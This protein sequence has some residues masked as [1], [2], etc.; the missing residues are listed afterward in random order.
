MGSSL[1]GKID[2]LFEGKNFSYL[3]PRAVYNRLIAIITASREQ[4]ADKPILHEILLHRLLEYSPHE[5]ATILR[6]TG[7]HT[8]LNEATLA[9]EQTFRPASF[10][11]TLNYVPSDSLNRTR[12]S[13]TATDASRIAL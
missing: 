11:Q 10:N 5:I 2:V 4:L 3:A 12:T 13:L 8:D 7:K 9:A 1:P 6:M